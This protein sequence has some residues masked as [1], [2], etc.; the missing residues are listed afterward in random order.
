M[1]PQ[2]TRK[3]GFARV[4]RLWLQVLFYSVLCGTAAFLMGL[5][6]FSVT[7]LVRM[8]L[9]VTFSEYWYFTDYVILILASP[10]AGRLPGASG[11]PG[12][13]S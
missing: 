1:P 5:E 4:A 2:G 9:P 3:A 13:P 10:C 7:S 8:P 6:P 12:K 11:A